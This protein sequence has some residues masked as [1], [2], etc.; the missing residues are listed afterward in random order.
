MSS[1]VFQLDAFSVGSQFQVRTPPG[2][3]ISQKSQVVTTILRQRGQFAAVVVTRAEGNAAG[4]VT[5][6]ISQ[7]VVPPINLTDELVIAW[8]ILNLS[9]P[10][11]LQGYSAYDIG[12]APLPPNFSAG[13]SG[14]TLT[15]LSQLANVM[16]PIAVD[17]GAPIGGVDYFVVRLNTLGVT[18]PTQFPQTVIT[19]VLGDGSCR[20]A[21]SLNPPKLAGA[22]LLYLCF[23][24][25]TFGAN[26]DWLLDQQSAKPLPDGTALSVSVGQRDIFNT[27][28]SDLV[29]LATGDGDGELP[30]RRSTLF[31]TVESFH[32]YIYTGLGVITGAAVQV[33]SVGSDA[34]ALALNYR[35][36]PAVGAAA[37][38]TRYLVDEF[39]GGARFT[40]R[41]TAHPNLANLS[42]IVLYDWDYNL[43]ISS[44]YLAASV[45]AVPNVSPAKP[46]GDRQWLFPNFF[47]SPVAVQGSKW[48]VTIEVTS[49]PRLSGIKPYDEDPFAPTTFNEAAAIANARWRDATAASFTV[50]VNPGPPPP[51]PT[52]PIT[53]GALTVAGTGNPAPSIGIIYYWATDGNPAPDGTTV[54]QVRVRDV[55][56]NTDVFPAW[57]QVLGPPVSGS[58]IL[59]LSS[60][61]I[62]AGVAYDVTIRLVINS[63][64]LQTSPVKYAGAITDN[65]TNGVPTLV[66]GGSL[67]DYSFTADASYAAGIGTR[68]RLVLT[69]PSGDTLATTAATGNTLLLYNWVGLPANFEPYISPPN[70]PGAI[71]QLEAIAP[72]G[73]F[74]TVY[75]GSPPTI[76]PP[77]APTYAAVASSSIVLNNAPGACSIT[78]PITQALPFPVLSVP[79]NPNLIYYAA[80]N[81]VPGGGGV[82]GKFLTVSGTDLVFAPFAG[83]VSGNT[84]EF[85]LF[86]SPAAGADNYQQLQPATAPF[87]AP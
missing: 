45:P 12:R 4:Y 49:S 22:E 10:D 79:N 20:Y 78:I 19:A 7:A 62:T 70:N 32:S 41:P 71:V 39:I 43:T 38:W 72:G 68:W 81:A 37:P 46:A 76:G 80:I 82:D 26:Y 36:A 60:P 24:T 65:I 9:S 40:F 67:S 47:G 48:T 73:V 16:C 44:N 21:R 52:Y 14:A 64:V 28:S 5:I 8:Q 25:R 3:G 6:T 15:Q 11:A 69:Y 27:A 17:G 61:I 56:T 51:P 75:S 86:V 50:G 74:V 1:G 35:Y 29:P 18:A 57:S 77:I 85:N 34:L 13:G 55:L 63:T 84:Y 54:Y 53:A 83:L 58:S 31:P 23:G 66:S 2:L 30:S 87:V 42:P 33:L 59:L